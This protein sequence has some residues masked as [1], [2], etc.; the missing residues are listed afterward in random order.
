MVTTLLQL[1]IR[2]QGHGK[3][4]TIP[5]LR[6]INSKVTSRLDTCF[7]G[8]PATSSTFH[9]SRISSEV[10][11]HP[12]I[13]NGITDPHIIKFCWSNFCGLYCSSTSENIRITTMIN[14][15]A[16][17]HYLHELIF[18]RVNTINNHTAKHSHYTL[19]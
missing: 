18:Q 13:F 19:V 5:F 14:K 15:K 8:N 17:T 9:S 6:S 7:S 3:E 2:C 10:N 12:I 4:F 16:P 1:F 11:L